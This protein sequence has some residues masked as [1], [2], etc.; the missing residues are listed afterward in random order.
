MMMTRTIDS[1]FDVLSHDIPLMSVFK[2]R[3]AL[4]ESSLYSLSLKLFSKYLQKRCIKI[5]TE[6]QSQFLRKLMHNFQSYGPN[7][8]DK[9]FIILDNISQNLYTHT[10]DNN[11]CLNL[12]KILFD[13]CILWFNNIVHCMTGM[14]LFYTIPHC[15]LKRYWNYEYLYDTHSFH[16]GL[17]TLTRRNVDEMTY[18]FGNYHTGRII[19]WTR[20][21]PS[22]A[23]AAE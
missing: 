17:R 10:L 13:V 9:K 4:N 15:T 3:L 2:I 1:F 11:F 5:K 18:R 21:S 16:I 23:A 6:R 22:R 19:S 8:E 20:T 7:L 14:S 12:F